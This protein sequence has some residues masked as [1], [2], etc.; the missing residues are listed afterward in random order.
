ML[1]S[2]PA[3]PTAGVSP[4]PFDVWVGFR[5][6]FCRDPFMRFRAYLPLL[7]VRAFGRRSRLGLSVA[8][9]FGLEC[10]T[11]LADSMAYYALC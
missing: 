10:L 9:P 2:A 7:I 1:G 11:S 8:P 5:R 3:W 4:R 6:L